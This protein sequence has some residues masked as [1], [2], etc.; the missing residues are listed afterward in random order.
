MTQK[1]ALLQLL[2]FVMPALIKTHLYPTWKLHYGTSKDE[3]E[4]LNNILL[5]GILA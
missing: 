1:F 4:R 5:M 3:I 2:P